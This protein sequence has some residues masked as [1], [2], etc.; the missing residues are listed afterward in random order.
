MSANDAEKALQSKLDNYTLSI[1]GQGLDLQLTAADAGLAVNTSSLIK[2]MLND[3][4]PWLW[5]FPDSRAARRVGQAG[6]RRQRKRNLANA[7]NRRCGGVSTPRPPR[8]QTPPISYN[9]PPRGSSTSSPNPW[10]PPWTCKPWWTW[11]SRR[12]PHPLAPRVRDGRAAA[13]AHDLLHR[14]ALE[15]GHRNRQH[16]DEGQRHPHHGR[17]PLVEVGADLIAEWITIDGEANA[18]L[19]DGRS[20]RLG[21]RSGRRVRHRGRHAQL[22]AP[23]RQADH[24]AGRRVRLGDRRRGAGCGR[25]GRRGRRG[26]PEPGRAHRHVRRRLQR[27]GRGGLGTAP[28]WTSTWPNSTRASTTKAVRSCGESDIVSGMPPTASTTPPPAC[29]G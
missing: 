3:V 15:R 14:S 16:H 2:D 17:P 26:R 4:N 11:R 18:A 5:P 22:R 20:E 21:R 8:P 13:A 28:T 24:R 25:E 12:F 6:G 10:A 1:S 23:R 29:T 27:A 19:G 7:V 9:P